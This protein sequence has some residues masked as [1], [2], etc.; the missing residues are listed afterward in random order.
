MTAIRD[1]IVELI[2]VPASSIAPHP[3]NFRR[4]PPAQRLAMRG[5]LN[6]IG[7]AGVIIAL[8]LADGTL[9][10]CDGHLRD[11]LMGDALVPVAVVDLDEDEGRKLLATYDPL[12]AMAQADGDALAG[13]LAGITVQDDDLRAMLETLAYETGADRV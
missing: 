10:A 8:R 12:G 5:A 11:E 6:E 2:R 1:R 4:H 9:Q 3:D 13:L 7:F